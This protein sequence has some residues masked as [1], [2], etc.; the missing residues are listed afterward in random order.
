MNCFKVVNDTA[1][2][3]IKLILDFNSCLWKVE[4]QW[5]FRLEIVSECREIFPHLSKIALFKPLQP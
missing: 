2:R 4:G 5:Q 1:E 3:G